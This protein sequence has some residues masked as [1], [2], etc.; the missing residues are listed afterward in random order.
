[1][2]KPHRLSCISVGQLTMVSLDLEEEAEEEAE[3]PGIGVEVC[4]GVG[5]FSR[6]VREP[7]ELGEG[8]T[9]GGIGREIPPSVP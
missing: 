4:E 2:Y 6:G 3:L 1:M 5:V 7:L 8:G 9:E